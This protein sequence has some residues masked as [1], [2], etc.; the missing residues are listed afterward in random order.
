VSC[1]RRP[2]VTG[3]NAG[4]D[5]NESRSIL[6]RPQGLM[7]P[8]TRIRGSREGSLPA[9]VMV[10]APTQV[11]YRLLR[12]L[13]WRAYLADQARSDLQAFESAP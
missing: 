9:M 13:L 5:R 2:Q 1:G 11:H 7:P 4:S 10:V 12:R 8:S 3:F 6:S